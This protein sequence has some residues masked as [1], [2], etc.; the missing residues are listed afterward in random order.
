MS[1]SEAGGAQIAPERFR[2]ALPD[3]EI[4]G[5]RWRRD[6]APRLL[7]C[8]ANGFCASAYRV[9]LG[10]VAVAADVWAIDLR[11]HGRTSLPADPAALRNWEVF[12]RDIGAFLD[13]AGGGAWR[14]AGHS[15]GAVSAT[16]AARGRT[17][18]DGLAL[19]EPVSVPPLSAL[20]A[21]TAPGR[22]AMRRTPL[23]RGA[24]ARRRRWPSR[25][26]ALERYGQKSV[27]RRWA[28]GVLEDYL[29]DGLVEDGEDMRLACD[30]AWE[31]AIFSC[32][33]R[34]FWDAVRTAPAPLAV[35]GAAG[36]DTTIFPGAAARFRR[37]GA[38]FSLAPETGH[39]LPMERPAVAAD[40]LLS[41]LA[42]E[43]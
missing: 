30:P 15:L 32:Q 33:S 20:F 22:A 26:D 1:I 18:V 36:R 12:G 28:P 6:G 42:V 41:A 17:D 43:P 7:F 13:R 14:L 37:A 31:S 11:G 16:L 23:A 35:L 39:L 4:A 25:A 27:F 3:G 21:S 34:G 5:W 10:A 8:H 2:I 29:A 19:I 9:V 38:R 40:F 24:L